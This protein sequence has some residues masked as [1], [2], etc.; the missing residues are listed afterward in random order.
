MLTT[1][2][3][4]CPTRTPRF[5]VRLA[6]TDAEIEAA[7]RL[8]YAVFADE[9]GARLPTTRPG[10]DHDIFDAYCD[11][12][13]V[14]DPRSDEVVG[15]YRILPPDRARRIGGLYAE[16]EFDLT[17]LQHLRPRMAEIGR[18]CVHADY[19]SG[20]VI[21]M[22]WIGLAEYARDRGCEYL[23]GCASVTM[24]D[25]GRIAAGVRRVLALTAPS[26]AEYRVFPRHPLPWESIEPD[27]DAPLPPLIRGYV[28]C[29]AWCCGDPAWD[30]DFNTADFLMLLS[31]ARLDARYL[32]RFSRG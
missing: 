2:A 6:R 28:R 14:K 32:K 23:A 18:S 13:I 22:L 24:V 5:D 29:G 16:T 19:R 1:V 10:I 27:R 30:P 31:M 25:G 3:P 9:L 4:S 26:P 21:A 7:Q 17:R 12:L 20:A 11:H 15:T 8:R